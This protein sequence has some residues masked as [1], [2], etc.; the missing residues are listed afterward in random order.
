MQRALLVLP[1]LLCVACA[2][3]APRSATG[4]NP[5]LPPGAVVTAPPTRQ[6]ST[7]QQASLAVANA[8][9]FVEQTRVMLPRWTAADADTGL[10]REAL[11]RSDWDAARRHSAEASAQADAALSDHYTRLA[12]EELR[13]AYGYT[14]L[15]DGQLALLD[16][17][18]ETLV[19]GN[20]RLA[21]GRL[22][23]L[24]RQ[25]ETRIKTH[26][27]VAGESLWIIAGKPEIYG[28]PLLWP[29]IWQ[30][31]IA[32]VPKPSQLRRGQVL[33]LRP[34]PTLEEVVAAVEQARGRRALSPRGVT[35]RIGEIRSAEQ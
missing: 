21:Y 25:L 17:A 4:A 3:R 24:N 1:F 28:N 35:P 2:Q 23:T 13:K 19:A 8:A 5:E 33:K 11:R 12:N 31:N 15:D 7:Q 34:H 10:A 9:A 30:D 16:A 26:T 32:V 14:G 22:R 20:S 27:V 6:T 18:E 29:L